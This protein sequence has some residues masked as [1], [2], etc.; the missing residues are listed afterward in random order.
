MEL[1][2]ASINGINLQKSYCQ[3]SHEFFEQEYEDFDGTCPI[4]GCKDITTVNRVCGFRKVH[5]KYFEMLE[6]P[7]VK[8]R[9]ISRELKPSTTIERVHM[10]YYGSEIE[11]DIVCSHMKI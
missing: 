6:T 9:T 1:E 5:V 8:A 11:N 4:C 7:N 10:K 2:W 3:F